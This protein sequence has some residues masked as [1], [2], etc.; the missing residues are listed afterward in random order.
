MITDIKEDSENINIVNSLKNLQ[1]IESSVF[2]NNRCVCGRFVKPIYSSGCCHI[3]CSRC[4]EKESYH[5]KQVNKEFWK[6]YTDPNNSKAL[7][8]F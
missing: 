5:T 8:H 4:G 3:W 1:Y 7:H 6:H 2:K